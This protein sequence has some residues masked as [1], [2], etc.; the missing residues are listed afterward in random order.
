MRNTRPKSIALSGGSPQRV[1]RTFEDWEAEQRSDSRSPAE[2]GIHV[3]SSV[4]WRHKHNR[5]IVTD[6][7]MVLAISGDTLT[8]Q[9]KDVRERTCNA[10]IREIVTN[11]TDR[12]VVVSTTTPT[13]V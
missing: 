3:G 9:V 13:R 10:H 4:M 6:R 11:E 8:L 7:A 5:L 12:S 1:Y 2:R